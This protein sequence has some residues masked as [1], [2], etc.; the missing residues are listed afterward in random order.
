MGN[1]ANPQ[2]SKQKEASQASDDLRNM[3]KSTLVQ[4]SIGRIRAR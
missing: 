4:L 2:T 3:G 1:A